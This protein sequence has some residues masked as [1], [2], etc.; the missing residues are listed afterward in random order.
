M[1]V[2]IYTRIYIDIFFF[3][4]FNEIPD[5]RKIEVMKLLVHLVFFL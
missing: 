3:V 2:Y 5:V 1:N 4:F